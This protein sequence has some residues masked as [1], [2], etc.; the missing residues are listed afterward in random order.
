MNTPLFRGLLNALA[1]E[2][3]FI[4]VVGLFWSLAWAWSIA[5]ATVVVIIA[6]CIHYCSDRR[7]EQPPFTSRYGYAGDRAGVRR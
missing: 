6:E 2:L 3:A 7:G 5:A 4:G 1:I